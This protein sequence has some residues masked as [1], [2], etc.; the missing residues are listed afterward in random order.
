MTGIMKLTQT[1]AAGAGFFAGFVWS[2][3]GWAGTAD[4]GVGGQ[5]LRDALAPGAALTLG[6]TLLLGFF[7]WSY[8]SA[9][10]AGG[11]RAT[12][13]PAVFTLSFALG[14]VGIR[15]ALFLVSG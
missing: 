15:G 2:V 14:F 13:A 1:M 10:R 8:L 4:R 5:L 9:P 6:Y 3:A 7:F 12:V 11:L